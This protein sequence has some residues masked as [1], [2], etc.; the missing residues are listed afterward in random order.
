MS[1]FHSPFFTQSFSGILSITL[2][3]SS[4]VYSAEPKEGASLPEIIP[5]T[6][7]QPK[8]PSLGE[9]LKITQEYFQ[10][11]KQYQPGDLITRNQMKP[12]FRQLQKAGWSVKSEP[13]IL[14][15]LHSES[16]FLAAQL[17]TAKGIKFMRKI[18]QLPGGYD[19]LDHILAMPYGKRRIKEFI[20][21][22]GGN[23]MIEYMTTTKGG[24]N[25]G[26]YLSKTKTGKGFNKPTSRIYTEKQLIQEIKR[27]YEEET[28]KNKKKR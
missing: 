13:K 7:T 3:F 18:S 1:F 10:G 22:P 5:E 21:S 6:K 19:R 4:Q 15:R 14:S 16:D 25:L 27:T 2:F 20:N 23:L 28:A 26:K 24:K 17:K 8:L 9:V 12:L 11:F